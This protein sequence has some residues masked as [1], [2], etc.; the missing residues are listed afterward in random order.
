MAFDLSRTVRDILS[1]RTEAIGQFVVTKSAT[2][3]TVTA[4]RCAVN[5][6]VGLMPLDSTTATEYGLGTTYVTPG[7]GS[8]VVTHPSNTSDRSYR[9]VIHFGIRT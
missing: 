1:G 4:P 6:W 2:T 8:F 3:T 9:Y 7:A 5:S